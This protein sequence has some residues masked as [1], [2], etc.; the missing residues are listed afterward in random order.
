MADM[1]FTP[2]Q[3]DA[4][5]ARGGSLIVSAAAGSGKT[6]VLV[7]RVIEMLL[8]GEHPVSA[9]KLLIVT[10]TKAAAEEMR[11]RIMAEVEAHLQKDPDNLLLRRQLVLLS[12]ADICTIHSFCSR[13]LKEHFAALDLSREFRIAEDSELS[14]MRHRILSDII[15]EQYAAKKDGFLLLSTVLSGSKDDKQLENT[16]LE[17]YRKITAHPDREK[18][19]EKAAMLYDPHIPLK[20]TVFGELG[21]QVLSSSLQYC[22]MMLDSAER[23]IDDNQGAFCTGKDTSGESVFLDLQAFVTRLSKAAEAKDWNAVSACVMSYTKRKYLPPRSKKYPVDDADLQTIKI[24]FQNIA[25]EIESAL[26]PVFGIT[27]EVYQNDTE[28]IYP[29]V[30]S[31]CEV[32]EELILRF[33][34]A[35]KEKGILDFSDLE[36]LTLQLLEKNGQKTELAESI[37]RQYDAVMIDEYQDTNEIQDRIFHYVSQNEKNLFV[38][39]DVKQSIYRFRE[40]MPLIFKNRRRASVR[41]DKDKPQFPACV[42]LDRNFRSRREVIDSVNFVFGAVMSEQVGEITYDETEQLTAGA[43]YPDNEGMETEIHLFAPSEDDERNHYEQEAAYIAQTIQGMIQKGMQIT[44]KGVLRPA[45]YGDFCILMRYLKSHAR[46]YADTMNEMGIPTYVDQPYSLFECYEVHIV[47]SLLKVIDNCLQDIPLSAVLL[48]PAFGFTPDDL[49]CLK[50]RWGNRHL[51]PQIAACAEKEQAYLPLKHK[52]HEFLLLLSELR[53]LSVTLR[54]SELAEAFFGKKSY[55]AVMSAMPN[56]E[57]RV[58]NIRKLMSFI[59]EYENGEKTSL[60]DFV[61]HVA[62]LE[63]HQTEI[64]IGDT[65]PENSVRIMSIHHSK[66]LEFPVCIMAGMDMTGNRIPPDVYCH[67]SLGF[68][69]KMVQKETLFQYNTLQRN[70]L[71]IFGQ[72]EER[73]EAMRILYVA[74]TRAKEKLIAVITADKKK[75]LEE[76]ASLVRISGGK[77]DP[78]CV[79]EGETLGNW[80]LMCA[81]AHPSMNE[82]RRDASVEDMIPIPSASRWKYVKGTLSSVQADAAVPQEEVP[83][84][85]ALL[86]L[87]Q[88]RF[89]Q[90]YR[91]HARTAIPAK[92]AASSLVHNGSEQE[93]I[94]VSRPAFMQTDRMTGAEKGT[95]MHTFLQYADFAA[96][97]DNAAAEK[98]HLLLDGR[99]SQQQYDSIQDADIQ[100]FTQSAT[101][102]HILQAEQVF[103]E[104]RFTVNISAK[105]VD[106]DYD[107]DETVILQG[108]MDCLVCYPDGLVIIDYKTD[109]VKTM[110][111][112]KEKYQK[113]LFLYRLA[114]EQ[115]F[116]KPVLQCLIYST[117]LGEEICI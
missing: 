47:L 51:Y 26:R 111:E 117:R 38:V 80:M 39:G 59:R 98:Q 41:Y 27:E 42:I 13:L 97:S 61:R 104:Y 69:M 9:D 50:I 99:L 87:L 70:L 62:Y 115:I 58:K 83:P 16:L 23:V 28:Q 12:N 77:I 57:T 64:S 48:C 109:R 63:E 46:E 4:I 45:R 85:T 66:G 35:K 55:I 94:A 91:Y 74:M 49:A 72:R 37:S 33:G 106:N 7:Q 44:E 68:G 81:L 17:V 15:E 95:A 67:P 92:V 8:D 54:V 101:Y 53:K 78:K 20:D 103:R 108:A 19:M 1:S 22:R 25:K 3:H 10:F 76:A 110:T 105:E 6:R 5:H 34:A 100:R 102:R 84:D 43:I 89:S 52:C 88:E 79:E 93:F 21:F 31:M 82:L 36:H 11:K 65:A 32:L 96:L 30:I 56:G 24:S 71:R 18:W 40:A 73:S 114:A 2:A 113:Q 116:Q 107:A 60:S 14:V 75:K 90:K 112:L 86:Q 29:A